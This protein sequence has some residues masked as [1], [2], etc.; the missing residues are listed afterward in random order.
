MLLIDYMNVF[1]LVM[2][3]PFFL[4]CSQPLAVKFSYPVM[5]SGCMTYKEGYGKNINGILT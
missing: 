2:E 4:F 5:K 3:E 1:S